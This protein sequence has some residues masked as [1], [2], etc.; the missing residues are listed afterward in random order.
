MLPLES[1]H[2][3]LLNKFE[4]FEG[5]VVEFNASFIFYFFLNDILQSPGT[6]VPFHSIQ[7]SHVTGF[8]DLFEMPHWSCITW[9]LFESAG[10]HSY[11]IRQSRVQFSSRQV[12]GWT[13]SPSFWEV[14]KTKISNKW[15]QVTP[16]FELNKMG[17]YQLEL[18]KVQNYLHRTVWK[19][20]L[21]ETYPKLWNS[22][23]IIHM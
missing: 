3:N 5:I 19:K 11:Q 10:R 23:I 2:G 14:F 15:P 22:S 12:S 21:V 18:P 13:L 8:D 1:N 16:L 6:T 17:Q 4:K 7:T 20:R 9:P